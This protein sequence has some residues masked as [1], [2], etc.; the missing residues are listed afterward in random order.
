[1]PEEH[2]EAVR[3]VYEGWAEGDFSASV[4]IFDPHVLLVMRPEFPDA[5]TY[6][7]IE[8][9]RDYTRDFLE[10]WTRITIEAE[11]IT[12]AGDSVVVAV[13]QRGTGG[14]SGVPT[15]FRYFHVWTFRGDRAI[16]LESIRERDQA[17]EA[18]GLRTG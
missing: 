14:G 12:A 18:V 16:R 9:V 15:E 11:E 6:L 3:R 5:G 13:H 1:M 8:G 2:V 4:D 17:L 7:G 10:P